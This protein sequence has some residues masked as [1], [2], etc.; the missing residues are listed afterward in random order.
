M[1]VHFDAFADEFL[2]ILLQIV[3]PGRPTGE[4]VT[5]EVEGQRFK[6]DATETEDD[7]IDRIRVFAEANRKPGRHGVQVVLDD[8]LFGAR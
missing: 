3:T 5:A 4:A 1:P 8:G 7:V 2:L 6:R